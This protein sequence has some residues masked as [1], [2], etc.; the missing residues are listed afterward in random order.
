MA[1]GFFNWPWG[2]VEVKEAAFVEEGQ[3]LYLPPE[4]S[5]L[6]IN[7]G[8]QT[9]SQANSRAFV[10]EGYLKNPTVRGI[11]GV[12]QDTSRQ[13]KWVLVDKKTNEPVEDALFED[14]MDNPSPQF[15]WADF[16]ANTLMYEMLDGNAFIYIGENAKS[17]NNIN[18]GM[19]DFLLNLPATSVG[20]ELSDDL[21]YIKHYDIDYVW[22]K[23]EYPADKVIHL[24]ESNPDFD[25]NG[26]DTFLR[27]K[28]R[29]ETAMRALETNNEIIDTLKGVYD[30]GGP[31]GILGLKAKDEFQTLNQEQIKRLEAAFERLY[32]GGRNAGK[33]PIDNLEWN[34]TKIGSDIKELM[35][36]E[37]LESSAIEICRAYNFPPMMIGLGNSTY[38]NQNEAKKELWENVILPR[39]YRIKEALNKRLVPMFNE[40]YMLTCDLS[41]IKALKEDEE[42]KA[43]Q[44]SLMSFLTV[45]EKRE[46]FGFEPI[47][48]G[49]ELT[50]PM[51]PM[52]GD[53][54]QPQDDRT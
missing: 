13:I 42:K 34:W 50:M 38:E 3:G 45:N 25:N 43:K 1:K 47:E 14:L 9:Y 20:I 46:A 18:Q 17:D 37:M 6:A 31:R 16:I 32:K 30:N 39:V 19:P 53:E 24:R 41:D 28:S 48:G 36:K 7:T 26:G 2:N 44:Y 22:V 27:G 51:P 11:I 21:K 15:S 23:G 35:I 29:L 52:F 5:N 4:L 33:F 49:D 54:E 12:T 8:K 10:R 40:N